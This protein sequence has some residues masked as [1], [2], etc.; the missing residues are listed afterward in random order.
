M[1]LYLIG[2]LPNYYVVLYS[3]HHVSQQLTQVERNRNQVILKNSIS[4][5]KL[6]I[7][8]LLLYFGFHRLCREIPIF[9]MASIDLERCDR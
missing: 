5:F 9:R 1:N 7:N 8:K 3:K 2:I 6:G 4:L